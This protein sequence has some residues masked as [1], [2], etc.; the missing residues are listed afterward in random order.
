MRRR[1]VGIMLVGVVLIAGCAGALLGDGELRFE[2]DETV[3]SEEVA[4]EAGDERAFRFLPEVESSGFEENETYPLGRDSVKPC[5]HRTPVSR[6]KPPDMVSW[7][8]TKSRPSGYTVEPFR[9]P[10]NVTV[11]VSKSGASDSE[12]ETYLHVMQAPH[13]DT[14]DAVLAYAVYPSGMNAGPSI[15]RL[16]GALEYTPPEMADE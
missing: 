12:P 13:P 9:E 8:V 5:S 3:V 10:A 4:T 16:F 15:A 7:R 2:S 14:N 6:S 11:F 1:Y